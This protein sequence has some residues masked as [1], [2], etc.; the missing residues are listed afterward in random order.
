[1]AEETPLP[2][3]G[4]CSRSTMRMNLDYA[5]AILPLPK[6]VQLM[7]QC[8]FWGCQVFV[9]GPIFVWVLPDACVSTT[10]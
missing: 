6:A 1:M 9:P 3:T 5:E 2:P 7:R 10:A 4:A 8:M